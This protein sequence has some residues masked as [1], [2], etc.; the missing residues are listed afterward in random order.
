MSEATDFEGWAILEI[1]GHRK[2]GGYVRPATVAGAAMLRVDVPA[3]SMSPEAVANGQHGA[4]PWPPAGPWAA[5]QY[6]A[7]TA[8]FCLTPVAADVAIRFAATCRPEPVTRWELPA[9]PAGEPAPAAR[10]TGMRMDPDD[11]P[12]PTDDDPEF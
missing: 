9:L 3:E 2:L 7:P 6:Y 12:D 11:E 4:G 8:L 10:Y 1:M 5:T